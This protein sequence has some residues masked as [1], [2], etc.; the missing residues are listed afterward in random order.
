[1]QL[2]VCAGRLARRYEDIDAKTFAEW[3]VDYLKLDG[4]YNNVTGFVT[5]Y[6]AMGAALQKSGRNI[7]YSCSWPVASQLPDFGR[8]PP[9]LCSVALPDRAIASCEGLCCDLTPS[10]SACGIQNMS[11]N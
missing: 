4:C 1:M 9:K 7:V 3:G 5:G 10:P 2:L 8:F 6:P 11:E